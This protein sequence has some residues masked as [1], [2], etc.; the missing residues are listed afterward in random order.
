M[1]RRPFYAHKLLRFYDDAS[2]AVRHQP[3]T[4]ASD[5][6]LP[7]YPTFEDERATLRSHFRPDGDTVRPV[8]D[9][10]WSHLP[11]AYSDIITKYFSLGE[12]SATADC[13]KLLSF[14]FERYDLVPKLFTTPFENAIAAA[15]PITG[16]TNPNVVVSEDHPV[17]V[18]AHPVST[19]LHSRSLSANMDGGQRAAQ[20]VFASVR[21]M[22]DV[23]AGRRSHI[24]GHQEYKLGEQHHTGNESF[25]SSRAGSPIP[26]GGP[27]RVATPQQ[28]RA[29]TSS[30]H[31]NISTSVGG[32]LN[33]N[34]TAIV[35]LAEVNSE[36]LVLERSSHH[37]DAPME[38]SQRG[39][40]VNS[41]NNTSS[42]RRPSEG[43]TSD[44]MRRFHRLV[45]GGH[46]VA[47]GAVIRG[48]SAGGDVNAT[49]TTVGDVMTTYLDTR[50]RTPWKSADQGADTRRPISSHPNPHRKFTKAGDSAIG[51]RP[52]SPLRLSDTGDI[53]ATPLS[54]LKVKRKEPPTNSRPATDFATFARQSQSNTAV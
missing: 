18:T 52:L 8:A 26:K 48:P 22:R 3:T 44:Q 47:A 17:D 2:P 14:I 10:R 25:T 38:T 16:G 15:P 9:K 24:R 53:Q 28:A 37:I 46:L 6:S 54:T 29:D 35:D 51:A 45:K 21:K 31:R 30:S 5:T 49:T 50:A 43:M 34:P 19:T 23:V 36:D 4:T 27:G 12:V 13:A 39:A 20:A 1:L 40:L 33:T 41:S 7:P 11:A 42:T 32:R